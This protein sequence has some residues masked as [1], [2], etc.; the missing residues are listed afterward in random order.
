MVI[1]LLEKVFHGSKRYFIWLAI[2][3]VGIIVGVFSY[4]QQLTYGLGLTGMS[5][6]VTWGLYIS[7]FTFLVGVAASGVMVVIPYYLHNYRAFAKMII[8]G[9][10]LAVAAVLMAMLFVF[11]DLGQPARVLNVLLYPT[12]HSIM[13]WDICVLGAYLILNIVIGWSVLLADKKGFPPPKWTRVLTIISIPLAISIHTVTAFLFA[14]LPGKEYWLSAI[15]AARFLSS[16]FASGPALL[17]L[18]ALLFRRFTSFKVSDESLNALSKIVCYAMIANIFFFVLEIFTAFYSAIPS[19]EASFLYLFFG[20]DGHASLVP[21]MWAAVVLAFVGVLLLLV[22]KLRRSRKVL[23]FALIAVFVACWLDKGIGLVLAGFVPDSFGRVIDY[24]PTVNE[25]LIICGVYALGL[26][27]L[28]ILYKVAVNVR[29]VSAGEYK[30]T[31]SDTEQITD[32]GE[33]SPT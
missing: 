26:F 21:I 10:F 8:L 23:P 4:T 7:Q 32:S 12:P 5:R 3:A 14:G 6:T 11:V 28:T 24:L 19:H 1:L 9:E 16:A 27:V 2:L 13:F 20:L 18:I 29:R 22:P 25:I 15:M 17:A 31:L 30:D 33:E